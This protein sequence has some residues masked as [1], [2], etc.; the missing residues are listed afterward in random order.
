MIGVV[1]EEA[2][3]DGEARADGEA[4]ADGDLDKALE[5]R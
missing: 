4:G 2:E 5:G 1:E 3:V